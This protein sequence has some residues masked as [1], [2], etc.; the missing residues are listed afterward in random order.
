VTALLGDAVEELLQE[1]NI[2]GSYSHLLS[3]PTAPRPPGM[4]SRYFTAIW[5]LPGGPFCLRS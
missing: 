4:Y 1:G 3:C 5:R 2:H